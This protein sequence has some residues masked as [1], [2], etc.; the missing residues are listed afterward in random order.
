MRQHRWVRH[1][2]RYAVVHLFA[3]RFH[4]RHRRLGLRSFVQCRHQMI[5][6]NRQGTAVPKFRQRPAPVVHAF[7]QPKTHKL[8]LHTLIHQTRQRL[9]NDRRNISHPQHHHA[10][11]IRELWSIRRGTA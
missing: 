9:L 2:D 5:F 1:P 6:G 7:A 4:S 8:N 11:N 10:A 3:I